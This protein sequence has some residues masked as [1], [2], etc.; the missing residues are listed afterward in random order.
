MPKI[1]LEG[2][3]PTNRTGYPPP[4]DRPVEGR[5]Y[6]RLGPALGLRDFGA[7]QVTLRPG[8]WSSQRHWHHGEDEFLVMVSG[9]AVLVDDDG[10]HTMRAGDCAAFPKGER[11]GH[12]LVNE[13]ASDCIFVVVGGGA[14]QGG[15]YSD[16][17]MVFTAD[18][19]YLRRDG[20]DYGADR[21][22]R[23]P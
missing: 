19:R 9:E 20:S 22:P 8:A 12:H 11:N 17:D 16:I 2:I 5:W 14:Q 13:S 21:V 4:F 3:T 23:A 10:R 6:R 1:D 15:E 7:S 18:G